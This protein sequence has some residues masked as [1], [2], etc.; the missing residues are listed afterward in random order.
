VTWTFVLTRTIAEHG[1]RFP[2][3][4]TAASDTHAHVHAHARM[5]TH[6]NTHRHTH[7]HTH[8]HTRTHTHTHTHTHTRTHTRTHA[9]V[10]TQG[11][12]V[13]NP[14]LWTLKYGPNIMKAHN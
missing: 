6:T 12:C 2:C 14:T 11:K 1:G 8:A 3:E 5:H 9:H 4:Q 7:T 10:D 13:M